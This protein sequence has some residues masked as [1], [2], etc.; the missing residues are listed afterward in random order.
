MSEIIIV[1]EQEAVLVST[2][3]A[4][5]IVTGLMGPP[6]KDSTNTISQSQDVD[7][8][9]LVNGATLVYRAS[10][11]KWKATNRLD[12]QILEAGQF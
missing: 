5:T 3:S 4:Q 11:A 8:T 2:D 9:D 10:D 7:T 12:N 6:G 1:N